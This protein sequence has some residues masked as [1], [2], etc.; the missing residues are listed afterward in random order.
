ML[1]ATDYRQSL[2]RR[3]PVDHVDGPRMGSEADER[4]LVPAVNAVG[5]THEFPLCAEL[6]AP[7]R[8]DTPDLGAP[9][10]AE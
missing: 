5:V 4:R 9:M 10:A 8:A 1:S 7:L 2:R 3:R 6:S